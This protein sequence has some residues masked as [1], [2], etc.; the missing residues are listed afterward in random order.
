MVY[1]QASKVPAQPSNAPTVEMRVQR[2]NQLLNL[3]PVQQKR[4]AKFLVQRDNE[5]NAFGQKVKNLPPDEA[6]KL[7]ME[8]KTK[9]E[10]QLQ[11]ILTPQQYKKLNDEA[12]K[13]SKSQPAPKPANQPVPKPAPQ[14]KSK[15]MPQIQLQPKK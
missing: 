6:Q 12:A 14:P 15:A 2:M 7:Q 5:R 11:Q 8:L 4:Y 1:S 10:S 3:T 13:L 9:Y